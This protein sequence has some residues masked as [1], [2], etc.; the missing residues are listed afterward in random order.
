[1]VPAEIP[2]KIEPGVT[3]PWEKIPAPTRT[4]LVWVLWFLTW[5]LL[6]AGLFDRVFYEYTVYLSAVHALL[7]LGLF[8]F[9]LAPFPVQVRLAYL[10]W[11]VVGTY[12]PGMTFLMC[13]S[14]L[15]LP[16]NL[17]FRY[18]PLARIMFLMPWNRHEPISA[19]LLKRTFLSAP[20]RGAFSPP[21][22]K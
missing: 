21:T 13:I 9:R 14:T 7:F 17:F 5:C 3:L 1:L 20:S 10:V 18:C 8:A 22:A 4:R 11:V 19:D 16:G 12:L 6:L 2:S 15:G